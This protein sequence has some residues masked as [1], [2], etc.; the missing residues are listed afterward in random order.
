[1]T[2]CQFRESGKE[3]SR[4]PDPYRIPPIDVVGRCSSL[5]IDDA[6]ES[7]CLYFRRLTVDLN[8]RHVHAILDRDETIRVNEHDLPVMINTGIELE[9]G[10]HGWQA[11]LEQTLE[12]RG[13]QHTI[14][15]AGAAG[16]LYYYLCHAFDKLMIYPKQKNTPSSW[17]KSIE[18]YLEDHVSAASIDNAQRLSFR[19]ENVVNPDQAECCIVQ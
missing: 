15:I 16:D 4:W 9:R 3:R 12:D 1:M 6:R 18:S 17:M 19:P 13:L 2:T 8:P 14:V 11:R 7:T 5:P 10:E